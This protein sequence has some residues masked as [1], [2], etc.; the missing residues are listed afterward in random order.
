MRNLVL[1]LATASAVAVMAQP[2]FAQDFTGPRVEATVGYDSINADVPVTPNSLDGV[3]IGG[4]VGYDFEIGKVLVIGAEAGFGI[5]ASG[6]VIIAGDKLTAGRDLDASIRVGARV[7]PRTMLYAKG[8]YVNSRFS[9]ES[10]GTKV[11]T[12]EDGWRAG[13]GVEH[14]INDHIYAKAEYRYSDYGDDVTR[15]QGLIGLGYRF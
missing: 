8:G 3:R 11:S 6:D 9:L 10:G 14:A 4:A 15:H 1:I 12:D 7:T 5:N 2:A 13:V